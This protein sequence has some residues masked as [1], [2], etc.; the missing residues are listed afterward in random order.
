[1][2]TSDCIVGSILISHTGHFRFDVLLSLRGVQVGMRPSR[3]ML[4]RS[5]VLANQLWSFMQIA[6]L[7]I[8]NSLYLLSTDAGANSFPKGPGIP[9]ICCKLQLESFSPSCGLVHP[10]LWGPSCALGSTSH[11]GPASIVRKRLKTSGC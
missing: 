2:G 3:S 10:A 11:S 1:M 5:E 6:A 9:F 7:E 8:D 4:A